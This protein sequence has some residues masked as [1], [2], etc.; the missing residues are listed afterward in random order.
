MTQLMAAAV[1]GVKANK[2]LPS[3]AFQSLKE[4]RVRMTCSKERRN[5]EGGVK[6]KDGR[7]GKKGKEGKGKKKEEKVPSLLRYL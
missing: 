1:R 3:S 5:G 7:K 2:A 6:V 4:V